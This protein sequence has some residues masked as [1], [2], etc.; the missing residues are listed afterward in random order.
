MVQHAEKIEADDQPEDTM[1]DNPYK[2]PDAPVVSSAIPQEYFRDTS[3]AGNL[4]SAGMLSLIYFV[5]SSLLMSTVLI[6]DIFSEST[7]LLIELAAD[8]LFIY[9]IL[10][11][12]RFLKKRFQFEGIEWPVIALILLTILSFAMSFE[13]TMG[14]GTSPSI[15]VEYQILILIPY[16]VVTFAL[17]YK[18]RQIKSDFP[19]LAAFAKINMALGVSMALIVTALIAFVLGPI[20]DILLAMIFFT[21]AREFPRTDRLQ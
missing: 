18:L 5:L 21:A 12:R 4:F 20:W 7:E 13:T 1:S 17:G 2:A 14:T 3:Y 10:F 16:G 9:L 19:Y 8:F 15:F 11:F 6:T